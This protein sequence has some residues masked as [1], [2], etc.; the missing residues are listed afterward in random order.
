MPVI[1]GL[2][3]KEQAFVA[4]TQAIVLD[5]LGHGLATLKV[6]GLALQLSSEVLDLKAGQSVVLQHLIT[7]V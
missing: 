6:L 4:A 7:T 1:Q 2:P 5:R 3:P